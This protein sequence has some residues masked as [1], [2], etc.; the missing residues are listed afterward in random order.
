M[1]SGSI[2]CPR[3][4]SCIAS[5]L[6]KIMVIQEPAIQIICKSYSV[7][8]RFLGPVILHNKSPTPDNNIRAKTERGADIKCKQNLESRS[9]SSDYVFV[10]CE[11]MCIRN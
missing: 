4:V 6:Y 5:Q 10:G 2:S 9:G 3:A 1:A 7:S 11:E 8:N